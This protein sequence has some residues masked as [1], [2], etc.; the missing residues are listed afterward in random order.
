MESSQACEDRALAEADYNFIKTTQLL[1]ANAYPYAIITLANGGSQQ[2]ILVRFLFIK[3]CYR[4]NASDR[5]L[6]LLFQDQYLDP[7]FYIGIL[8]RP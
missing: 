3:S 4:S 1:N 5:A 6:G 8:S 2:Y 7:S